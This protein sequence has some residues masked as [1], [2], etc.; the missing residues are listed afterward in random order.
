MKIVINADFGG[1]SVSDAFCDYYG[2]PRDNTPCFSNM[3][4]LDISRTDKRLI[5]YIEKFGT[6]Q[7]SG[8]CACLKVVDI[9]NGAKYRIIDYDGRES[10]QYPDDIT[11][12]TAIDNE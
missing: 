5:E 3:N 12:E 4:H 8:A 10:I 7:A 6:I 9:P 1:F 2:I 11:W